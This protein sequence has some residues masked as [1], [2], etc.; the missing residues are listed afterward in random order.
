MSGDAHRTDDVRVSDLQPLIS[1]AILAAEIPVSARAAGVVTAAR[2]EIE[3]ILSGQSD[4]LL[5]VVGPCSIHDPDAAREY[6]ARLQAKAAELRD[7]LLVV[8]RVYFEKPRTRVGWKGLIS[9]PDIDGTFRINQGLRVARELLADLADLGLPA[10]SEFLDTISPQFFADLVSWGAIGAR[11]AESQV[12]RELA[13][14]LSMPVGFKNSTSGHLTPAVHAIGAARHPHR[15]LSVTKEG[16]AAIVATVGNPSCHLILRGADAGPNFD[17]GAVRGAAAALREMGLPHRLMVDCSHGNS[18]KD[19]E[20][21][22]EVAAELARQIAAGSDVVAGVMIESNLVGGR[23]APGDEPRVRGRSITD[24][25]LSMEA[26]IPVLE[27]LASAVRTRR[28]LP[29]EAGS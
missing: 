12:H 18:R 14:G 27:G 9:D 2:R 10:G 15:F 25:C 5:A 21:Q 3:E 13:S 8:M 1:P 24:A 19:H 28:A 22:P 7:D 29:C 4:R 16:N 17:E 20:R 23:Q 11:T 6:A 26:T